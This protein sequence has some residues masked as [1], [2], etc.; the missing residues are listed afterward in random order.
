VRIARL[1]ELARDPDGARATAALHALAEID[2][3]RVLPTLRVA[4]LSDDPGILAAAA[5]TIAVRSVDASKRDP[6]A[7]ELLETLVAQR[8]DAGDLEARLSAIEALGAL[9]RTAV[10]NVDPT[11][12]ATPTVDPDAPWLAQ[13]IVPL[14]TDEHISIRRRAREALLGHP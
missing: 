3:P 12:T 10:A 4:L 11:P 7:V 14:A 2:D 5:T 1:I 8:T 6:D 9:A 13:T